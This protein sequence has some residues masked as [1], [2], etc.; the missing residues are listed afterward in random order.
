MQN[1]TMESFR[2]TGI[3][4]RTTNENG[5]SAIAIPKLWNQFMTENTMQQIAGKISNDIYCVYTEYEKDFTKPYTT[6]LGCRVEDTAP[7]QD[8]F[9][10][11]LIPAGNYAL[12]T[13]K[14]NLNEGIVFNEWTAIW[15]SSLQRAYTADFEIY[16]EKAQNPANAAVEIFVAI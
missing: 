14:G 3:A 10:S 8:G 11:I 7:G 9:K 1:R 13:A 16:G 2:I 12:F 4:I 5:A 15:N 6:L